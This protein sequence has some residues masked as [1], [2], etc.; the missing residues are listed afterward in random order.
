MRLT[1]DEAKQID[2]VD[3]LASLGYTPQKVRGVDYW[4]LSPLRD[5]K[6]ASFKVDRKQNLW[7]DHGVGQGG[8]IIDFGIAY[9]RCGI[10]DFMYRLQRDFSFHRQQS[11]AG[12]SSGAM[13]C[14]HAV[15]DEKKKIHLV[16]EREIVSPAL[17]RYLAERCIPLELARQYCRE[18]QFELKERQYYA[19][20]FRND[21][22]GFELRNPGF[23]GSCSPKFFTFI[24]S[25]ETGLFVFEGCF[26]L[27][28]YLVIR[29]QH[30][31]PETNYL[32]LNSLSAFEAS[33][34]LMQQFPRITLYLDHDDAGRKLTSQAMTQN[35][36]FQDGSRL[37]TGAKDLNEWHV[38][39][40]RQL[41]N[42]ARIIQEV[43]ARSPGISSEDDHPPTGKKI[44]R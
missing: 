44:R 14:I 32:V 28:S 1:F 19:I 36:A 2:L 4:Y 39:Q 33:L 22:G 15:A 23:K 13:S 8:S 10:A 26:D 24:P 40:C 43:R 29:E 27:L 31:L 18:V 21:R 42:A 17:V 20:G 11:P 12:T 9:F 3:Y 6:N 30:S 38:K 5:E 7:F 25:P 34:P 16:S 35:S 41:R 37:Y